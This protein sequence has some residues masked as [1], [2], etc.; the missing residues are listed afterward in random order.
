[1]DVP[2]DPKDISPTDKS[3]LSTSRDMSHDS[4]CVVTADMHVTREHAVKGE[5]QDACRIPDMSQVYLRSLYPKYC[6]E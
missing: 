2:T 1:M 5:D 4:L 6:A 3:S